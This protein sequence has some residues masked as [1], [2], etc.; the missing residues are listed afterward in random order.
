MSKKLPI[1]PPIPAARVTVPPMPPVPVT[2][3]TA[4]ENVQNNKHHRPEGGFAPG[5]PWSWKPGQSGNPGGRPK[6]TTE[7][8]QAAAAHTDLAL[9]VKALS[10]EVARR[11]LEKALE[12]LDDPK[13]A[14]IEELELAS[15]AIDNAA[16]N[17]AQ[18]MLD[19]GHGKPVAKVDLNV[20]DVF[21][22]MSDEELDNYLISQGLTVVNEIQR[23]AKKND[24]DCL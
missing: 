10:L 13:G 11:K 23:K 24:N 18:A 8:R 4:N 22:Q 2:K 9:R 15:R 16:L 5:N 19:R 21:S 7:M 6:S 14:T 3:K 1:M 20:N 12:I 17:A